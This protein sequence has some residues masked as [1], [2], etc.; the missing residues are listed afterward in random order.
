MY[1][2]MYGSGQPLLYTP[3]T[4][5]H[6]WFWPT[7]TVHTMYIHTCMVLD[8]P[9]CTH[10]VH[11]H[12][13]MILANPYC[14][15]HVHTHMYGSGQPSLCKN[16]LIEEGFLAEKANVLLQRLFRSPPPH[17][18][19]CKCTNDVHTRT[20]MLTHPHTLTHTSAHTYTHTHIHT[21]IHTRTHVSAHTHAQTF[22]HTH[23]NVCSYT[24]TH[25]YSPWE[26][27]QRMHAPLN[28]H[29]YKPWEG[30]DDIER[31]SS[32]PGIRCRSSVGM[33]FSV[34]SFDFHQDTVS[35]Q[36]CNPPDP[37]CSFSL[38]WS[39]TVLSTQVAKWL[40]VLH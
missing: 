39:F 32:R 16:T 12:T 1:T 5:I 13:C 19:T 3:C 22:T 40:I 37:R 15:H 6:V 10:H 33:P 9:Y 27:E 35:G 24:H 31:L 7:L 38:W 29:S 26:D 25:S 4:Y 14:T 30:A 34:P 17:T 21:H 20:H 2:H 28:A 18:Q 11:V 8:N 36:A 23:I